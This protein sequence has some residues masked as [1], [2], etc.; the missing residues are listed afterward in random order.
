MGNHR[1]HRITAML[2][3]L[4]VLMM[5]AGLP[6]QAQHAVR[7]PRILGISHM[8]FFVSNLPK[9]LGFWEN[10]L[11]YAEPYDLKRSDG[12]VRIAFIKINNHQHIELFKETPKIPGMYF[13]HLAFIVSNAEQMREYLASRGIPVKSHVGKGKTGDYNFE[14]KDP[15]DH[16][17]EFVQPLP[18]GWEAK[19]RGKFL[20][21]TRISHAIY[22]AGFMVAN[23]QKSLAFYEGI[24]GFKEFWRGS[25]NGRTLSWIDL[26]VPNG[27]D[28]IE[29][30]LYK[31]KLPQ[32]KWGTKNHVSLL[33][34]SVPKAIA[35][36]E[37]RPWYKSVYLT[38]AKPL[39][40]QVGKNKHRLANVYGPDGTRIELMESNTATG[41][42]TPSSTAPPP[43]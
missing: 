33:V 21:S 22:H 17:I 25:S 16:L 31:K 1:L 23:S 24:L 35:S 4:P 5:L 36:L 11:G 41:K 6:S 14:I 15:D 38:Y 26:R 37:S 8:G 19:N 9:A 40:V 42:P 43:R 27:H 30:M 7:R 29:L 20:P 39:Y 32:D 28:Y 12:S 18:T 2:V 10:F 34:P 13:S 3:V